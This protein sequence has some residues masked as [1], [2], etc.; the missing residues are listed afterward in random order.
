MST[1]INRLGWVIVTA[2]LVSAFWVFYFGIFGSAPSERSVAASG[3]KI[4]VDPRRSRR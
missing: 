1:F 4:T 3:E 2:V